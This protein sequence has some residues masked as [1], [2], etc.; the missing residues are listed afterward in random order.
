MQERLQAAEWASVA[1]AS[2]GTVVLGA[3]LE[4]PPPGHQQR[5]PGKPAAPDHLSS[6]AEVAVP[7][8]FYGVAAL[9]PV[10]DARLAHCVTDS[11][12]G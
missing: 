8:G 11:K 5:T 3:T 12:K 10:K 9:S 1:V 4:D 2:L 7:A 6:C